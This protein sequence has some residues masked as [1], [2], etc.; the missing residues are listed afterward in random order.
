MLAP[1]S[2]LKARKGL[3]LKVPYLPKDR[4]S[5]EKLNFYPPPLAMSSNRED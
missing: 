5:K 4:Y 1:L 3:S 2:L